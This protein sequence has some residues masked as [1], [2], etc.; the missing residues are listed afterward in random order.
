MVNEYAGYEAC[1]EYWRVA[2]WL[3]HVEG[4]VGRFMPTHPVYGSTNADAINDEE[5]RDP[6]LDAKAL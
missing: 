6:A 1:H 5:R 2:T 4:N 3:K